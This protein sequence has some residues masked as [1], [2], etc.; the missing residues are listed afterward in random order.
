M[1]PVLLNSEQS[2]FQIMMDALNMAF[3]PQPIVAGSGKG[4][5]VATGDITVNGVVSIVVPNH[6]DY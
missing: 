3:T 1:E 2:T 6:G 5:V 4:I